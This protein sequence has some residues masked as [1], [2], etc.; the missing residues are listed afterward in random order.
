VDLINN[1]PDVLRTELIGGDMM[2]SRNSKKSLLEE[3]LLADVKKQHSHDV[4]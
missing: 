2:K 4:L 3:D 1:D